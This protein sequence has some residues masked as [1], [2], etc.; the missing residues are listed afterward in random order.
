MEVSNRTVI[1]SYAGYN[2]E[3][4][5]EDMLMH[6]FLCEN[7]IGTGVVATICATTIKPGKR[8]FHEFQWPLATISAGQSMMASIEAKLLAALY[9]EE[10]F[11]SLLR[12]CRFEP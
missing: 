5:W 1:I 11:T 8:N 2:S 6:W 7:S 9:R 4:S 3:K 12:I 10:S